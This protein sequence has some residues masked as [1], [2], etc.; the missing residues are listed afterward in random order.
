MVCF[1]FETFMKISDFIPSPCGNGEGSFSWVIRDYH[2]AFWYSNAMTIIPCYN[3]CIRIFYDKC[4]LLIEKSD[5]RAAVW[6][7]QALCLVMPNCVR[8][9]PYTHDRF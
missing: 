5:P 6:L 8:A 4:E 2:M 3:M 1:D 7:H 9:V